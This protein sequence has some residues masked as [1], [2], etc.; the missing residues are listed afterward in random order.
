[1]ADTLKLKSKVN[2]LNTLIAHPRTSE[3]E[4]DAARRMLQRLIAKAR[5]NGVRLSES[6][7][8]DR[9]TY[10][11][12]YDGTHGLRTVDIAKLI[13]ADIKM[14][15][16]IGKKA[17]ESDGSALATTDPIANAPT[18]ITY[19]VRTRTYAAGGSSIDVVIKN[20]PADWGWT[21][22]IDDRGDV[23]RKGTESLGALSAE[24]QALLD[25]YNY[26][27]SDLAGDFSDVRFHGFV[28]V[29]H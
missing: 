26:D 27:G 20:V 17:Q 4:R 3:A 13:R 22:S 29:D 21:E 24:L 11:A 19:S 28:H 15:R 7:T 16:K 6:G 2:L 1:M 8:V 5:A 25:A 12:K 10:G 9:R 23:V 14:A 18:Q